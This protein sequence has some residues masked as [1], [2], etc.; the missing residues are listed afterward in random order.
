MGGLKVIAALSA[1]VLAVSRLLA[2]TYADRFSPGVL[3][4]LLI[5]SVTAAVLLV[6]SGSLWAIF[7]KKKEKEAQ[8]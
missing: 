4:A 7:A 2:Y 5:I 6:L 1:A 3:R 8:R